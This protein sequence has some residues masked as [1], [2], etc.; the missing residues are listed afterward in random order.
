MIP[1]DEITF[2]KSF[3]EIYSPHGDEDEASDFLYRAMKDLGLKT[4]R[5]ELGNV[6]GEIGE[7]GPI[8]FLCGHM[9]TVKGRLPVKLTDNKL[10]GRGA[11]DAKSALA[12][13]IMAA[14]RFSRSS[15]IGK[16]IVAAVVDEEGHSKGIRELIKKDIKA[17]YAIFGEP[18]HLKNITVGY[19]GTLSIHVNIETCGGHSSNPLISNAIEEAIK[20]WSN[21]KENFRKYIKKSFRS[22][23][24]CSINGFSNI[25]L[26]KATIHLNFR[27]PDKE[28]LNRIREELNRIKKEFNSADHVKADIVEDELCHPYNSDKKSILVSAL[29]KAIKMVTGEDAL[30]ISKTGTG[31]MN[32]FGAVY[33]IPTVTYGPGDSRLDHTA[34]EAID[35]EEYLKSIDVLECCIRTLFDLELSRDK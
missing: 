6:V 33:G 29:Q 1:M 20:L 5:T 10:Y 16:I 2:L 8:I 3:V 13:M 28:D 7:G 35:L 34:D 25:G 22:S 12:A 32:I 15:N 11:V 27:Y 26:G 30:L 4:E 14:S 24:I 23:I 19:K 9:D 17:D 31:D 18:S 21:I